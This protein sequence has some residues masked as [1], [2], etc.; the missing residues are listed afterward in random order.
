MKISGL[1]WAEIWSGTGI[2]TKK[3]CLVLNPSSC[4]DR[5]NPGT[6]LL[7]LNGSFFSNTVLSILPD[8][9]NALYAS[10]IILHKLELYRSRSKTYEQYFTIHSETMVVTNK[11]NISACWLKIVLCLLVDILILKTISIF[12]FLCASRKNQNPLTVSLKLSN[13]CPK[14]FLTRAS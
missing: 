2:W 5:Q 12:G 11:F 4:L 7:V 9:S 14:S 6:C 8:A 10:Y 13:R 1:S 3:V